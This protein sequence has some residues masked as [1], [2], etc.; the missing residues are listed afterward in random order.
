MIRT[1]WFGHGDDLS[2]HNM[3]IQKVFVEEL[4]SNPNIQMDVDAT[5]LVVYDNILPVATG[6]IILENNIVKLSNIGV[7]KEFRGNK[8]GDLVVRMFIRKSFTD[9]FS[10]QYVHAHLKAKGFYEKIGFVVSDCD[11]FV[12]DSEHVC[13]CH[14]GDVCG[15]CM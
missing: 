10:K 8:Y 15:H 1:K 6:K 4:K 7:L 14:T 2:D 11:C 9:G 5:Y 3:I 12:E 13:M